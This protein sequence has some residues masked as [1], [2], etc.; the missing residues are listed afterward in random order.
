MDVGK[1]HIITFKWKWA[2]N[3]QIGVAA[4][5]ANLDDAFTNQSHG[6]GVSLESG[7]KIHAGI[8]EYWTLF[9]NTN[10]DLKQMNII[11]LIFDRI[12]G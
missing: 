9:S 8:V 2:T 12:Q 1:I 5:L 7:G 11:K 3:I 6:F 10:R 4:S